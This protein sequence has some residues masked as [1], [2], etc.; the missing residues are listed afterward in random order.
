MIEYQPWYE[1]GTALSRCLTCG[2]LVSSAD[3]ETHTNWHEA[4]SADL[5]A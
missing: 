1:P 4:L 5:R 3:T 2:S